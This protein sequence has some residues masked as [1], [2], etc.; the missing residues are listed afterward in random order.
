MYRGLHARD[1]RDGKTPD[2]ARRMGQG[3]VG[4]HE[5]RLKPAAIQPG[6]DCKGAHL[7]PA[8]LKLRYKVKDFQTIHVV[9]QKTRALL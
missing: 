3:P 5:R 9:D 6:K 7:G 4:T 2:T 8:Q 1:E